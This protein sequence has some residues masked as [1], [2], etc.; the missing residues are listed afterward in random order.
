MS[1]HA[2]LEIV[3]FIDAR[4]G[5]VLHFC[6]AFKEYWILRGHDTSIVQRAKDSKDLL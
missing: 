5:Y 1:F 6:H 3:V 2:N 4:N